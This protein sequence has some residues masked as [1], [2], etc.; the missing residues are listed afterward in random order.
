LFS[1]FVFFVMIFAPVID[2]VLLMVVVVPRLFTRV[3]R[4]AKATAAHKTYAHS[5]THNRARVY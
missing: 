5:H 3:I 1:S 4:S 2:L